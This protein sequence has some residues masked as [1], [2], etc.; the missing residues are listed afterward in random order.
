[1]Y[2]IV[3]LPEN[4]K[5]FNGEITGHKNFAWKSFWQQ[6]S[7]HRVCPPRCSPR[8]SLCAG[9]KEEGVYRING[10]AK[11][12]E[13]LKASFNAGT[14]YTY[15]CKKFG[16]KYFANHDFLIVLL[17]K[18]VGIC[19]VLKVHNTYNILS[20]FHKIHIFTACTRTY[21]VQR[22]IVMQLETQISRMW[23]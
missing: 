22:S 16:G 4:R 1:M 15:L 6:L 12:I 14:F 3:Y 19:G 18:L 9:L 17:T 5:L 2:S 11:T 8:F 10:S 13:K 23:M 7:N 21:Y 20:Q